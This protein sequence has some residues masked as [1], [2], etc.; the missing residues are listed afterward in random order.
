MGLVAQKLILVKHQDYL[1]I[2][3]VMVVAV[4]EEEVVFLTDLETFLGVEVVPEF[5]IKE[6]EEAIRTA[7]THLAFST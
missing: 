3:V 2:Q 4:V 5:Q 7:S 6:V 1:Q